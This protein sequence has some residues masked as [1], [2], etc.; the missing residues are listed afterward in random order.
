MIPILKPNPD[1]PERNKKWH[2]HFIIAPYKIFSQKTHE[3]Q[4]QDNKQANYNPIKKNNMFKKALSVILIISLTGCSELFDIFEEA[5]NNELTEEKVVAG[6]KEALE[7]GAD[8]AASTLAVTNGY[9]K[10]ELVKIQLPQE[11]DVIVN[12]ISELPYGQELIQSLVDDVIKGINRSAEDAAKE[13]APVFAHAITGMSIADGWAILN[14]E[15]NAATTYLRQETFNELFNLYQ[16]KIQ[17]SLDKKIVGNVSTN[18]TWNTLTTEWNKIAGS[19]AG[20]IAGL[21]TVEIEL[22]SH[23]TTQA[24]DG[25]FLKLSDEEE[26]IRTTSTA[27]VTDLLKEVFG[28]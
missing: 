22:D 3:Y 20:E 10:D 8:S 7:I 1:E 11:A 28:R 24:L 27:R 25:L 15:N 12:N 21:E 23:L 16:P 26:K 13:A 4:G 9:Y 14:G 18:Q 6:L 2:S 5:N 17:T 19:L